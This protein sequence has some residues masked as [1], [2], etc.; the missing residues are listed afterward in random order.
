VFSQRRLFWEIVIRA[1]GSGTGA[2]QHID[3]GMIT[4]PE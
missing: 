4:K 2:P 1:V 3:C